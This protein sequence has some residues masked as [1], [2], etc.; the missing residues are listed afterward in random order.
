MQ[1]N[2]NKPLTSLAKIKTNS[3]IQ[4]KMVEHL[5]EFPWPLRIQW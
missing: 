5:L 3:K 1:I 4:L 2:N